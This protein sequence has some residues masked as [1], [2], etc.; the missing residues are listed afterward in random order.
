LYEGRENVNKWLFN[1]FI[2]TIKKDFNM[3]GF[4]Y[5]EHEK[6]ILITDCDYTVIWENVE[7][8]IAE[9]ASKMFGE[10][11]NIDTFLIQHN[12]KRFWGNTNVTDTKNR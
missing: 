1:I 2:E 12:C 4:K 5:D 3:N 6:R 9:E 8:C 11:K 7:K 10:S